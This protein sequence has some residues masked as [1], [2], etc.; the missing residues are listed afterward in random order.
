LKKHATHCVFC[1]STDLHWQCAHLFPH[2]VSKSIS[3]PETPKFFEI[4]ASVDSV[5]NHVR[6][7]LNCHYLFDHGGFEVDAD[8]EFKIIKSTLFMFC[9]DI[10]FPTVSEQ[11]VMLHFKN[12]LKDKM[13][14]P[15]ED[16]DLFVF[17]PFRGTQYYSV[18]AW[19][20]LFFQRYQDLFA[21][22]PSV[23]QLA[24]G[25]AAL[26]LSARQECMNC[27]EA[28]LNQ[29]C[30]FLFCKRCCLQQTLGC[31]QKCKLISHNL[32]HVNS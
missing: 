8:N 4:R 21:T 11:Q 13:M 6:A 28:D 3:L 10:F 20:R 30:S 19:R 24:E 1:G 25:M 18:W 31:A 22:K 32:K 26:Q 15:K 29:N 16:D 12:E 9:K 5:C 2:A 23:A 17:F 14:V 27:E 7:C